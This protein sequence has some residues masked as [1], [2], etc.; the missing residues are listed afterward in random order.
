MS[1]TVK[2]MIMRDYTNRMGEVQEA[3]VL[4]VRGLTA[5]DTHKLRSGLAKKKIKVTVVRNALAKKTFENHKLKPLGE[6]L[7]GSSALAYGGESI[8]ELAREV[9]A[10]TKDMAKVELRAA[11]LDGTVY[12]GK[13]GVKELSEFPTKDEAIGQVVTLV[14]SPAKK[15]MGQILGPGRTVAGLV[16]AIEAKLEKGEAIAKIA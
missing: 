2:N 6:F 1:K 3:L 15:A 16:K 12:K 10:L 13:N 9:V 11:I 14:L 8:V 5:K 7:T 4:G